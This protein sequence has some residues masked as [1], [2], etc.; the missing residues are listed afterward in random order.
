[1]TKEFFI[2]F[3]ETYARGREMFSELDSIGFNLSYENKRFPLESISDELFEITID[4]LYT[5]NGH[6]LITWYIFE[7]EMG[8]KCKEDS[9]IDSLGKLY[10]AVYPYRKGL[11]I[12]N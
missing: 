4:S 2:Q 11:N 1:M 9:P 6:D 10:D 5:E 7:C 8:Q 3:I 12:I